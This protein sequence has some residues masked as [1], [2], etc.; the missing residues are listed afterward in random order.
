M[1]NMT[2]LENDKNHSKAGRFMVLVM[3]SLMLVA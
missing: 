2:S 1:P 3:L